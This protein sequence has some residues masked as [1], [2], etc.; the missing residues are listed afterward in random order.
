M[1]E[2]NGGSMVN[3][4][5]IGAEPGFHNNPAHGEAKGALKQLTK[6]RAFDQGPWWISR[7]SSATWILPHRHGPSELL[8][9]R[10]P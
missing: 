1:K 2:Q 3:V 6:S 10:A 8:Q 7:Q 5:S 9:S 4:T